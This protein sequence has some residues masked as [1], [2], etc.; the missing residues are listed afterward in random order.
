MTYCKPA[1]GSDHRATGRGGNYIEQL[2]SEDNFSVAEGQKR[3]LTIPSNYGRVRR[4]A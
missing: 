2:H 1:A 3:W 4:S